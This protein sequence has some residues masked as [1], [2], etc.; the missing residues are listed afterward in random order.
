M[1]RHLVDEHDLSSEDA[2][3]L[4][5]EMFAD[6]VEFRERFVDTSEINNLKAENER[7]KKTIRSLRQQL[8]R[9]RKQ[10]S[11]QAR[12]DQDYLPYQEDDYDR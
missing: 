2:N 10:Q 7:L 3:K 5:D 12:Y 1:V 8:E 4:V 11:R 9:Y 6:P